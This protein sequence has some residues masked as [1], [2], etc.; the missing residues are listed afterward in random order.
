MKVDFLEIGGCLHAYI[1]N[2]IMGKDSNAAWC[3]T[4]GGIVMT[5][6]VYSEFYSYSEA[7]LTKSVL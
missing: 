3:I 5:V 2:A 6:S 7:S 4:K 1:E